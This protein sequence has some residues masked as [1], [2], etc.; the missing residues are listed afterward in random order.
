MIRMI[1]FEV[2][3]FDKTVEFVLVHKNYWQVTQVI[4]DAHI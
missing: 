2:I 1:Y 4:L 3:Q